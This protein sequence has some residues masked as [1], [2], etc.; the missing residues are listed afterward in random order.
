MQS[1]N[2]DLKKKKK[3]FSNFLTLILFSFVFLDSSFVAQ[4]LNDDVPS[5]S[6]QFVSSDI[7]NVKIRTQKVLFFV[8]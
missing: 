7:E 8:F 2:F 3:I 4:M 6:P 5:V 1:L